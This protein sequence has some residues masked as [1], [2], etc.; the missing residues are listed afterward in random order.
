MLAAGSDWLHCLVAAGGGCDCDCPEAEV[1]SL[2]MMST[3]ENLEFIQV[4]KYVR[5]SLDFSPFKIQI[6]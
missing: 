4:A 1:D 6:K 3:S 5:L 2:E